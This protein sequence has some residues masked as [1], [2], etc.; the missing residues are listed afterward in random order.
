MK[1]LTCFG[2]LA[3]LAGVSPAAMHILPTPHYFEPL[4]RRIPGPFRIV[5]EQSHAKLRIAAEMIAH[6][7]PASLVITGSRMLSGIRALA[8]VSERTGV[9]APCSVLVMRGAKQA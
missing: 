3:V 1:L 9:V 5:A 4:N 7:L 8:S 6:E 2:L